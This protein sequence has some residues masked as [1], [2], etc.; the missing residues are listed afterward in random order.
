MERS[1]PSV[2]SYQLVNLF[3]RMA[4]GPQPSQIQ[5]I[6]ENDPQRHF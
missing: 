1:P 3:M 4:A 2:D 6:H 5:G